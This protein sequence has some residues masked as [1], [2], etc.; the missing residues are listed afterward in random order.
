MR[1]LVKGKER[2][3]SREP[4]LHRYGG[5]SLNWARS[6][7][8][9]LGGE[10]SLTRASLLPLLAL[11]TLASCEEGSVIETRRAQDGVPRP[12]LT[13][14]APVRPGFAEMADALGWDGGVP[15][16]EVRLHR[17][18]TPLDQW[19][20]DTTDVGGLVRFPDLLPG[21]YRVAAFRG[22]E[23]GEAT[24]AVARALADGLLHV[25]SPGDSIELDL[26]LDRAGLMI[27]EIYTPSHDGSDTYDL[28]H[29]HRIRNA[30]DQTI[31]LDGMLYGTGFA[32]IRDFDTYF[33][34]ENTAR[35]R[36]DPEGLWAN[37]IHRFPGSGFEYPIRPG[38]SKVIA[39][40][41][42]DHRPHSDYGIDLRGA[43]F[44][45]LGPA[46]VDN[47]AVPNMLD[48]GLEADQTSVGHGV[49]GPPPEPW[50]LSEPVDLMTAPRDEMCGVTCASYLRIPAEAVIDV[51][52]LWDDAYFDA[53][54]APCAH[55][56][57]RRF[58]RL[59]GG[60]FADALDPDWEWSALRRVLRKEDGRPIP[61][62]TDVTLVDFEKVRRTIDG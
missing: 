62:D 23:A 54:A 53:Q 52:V 11:A 29:Y 35:F 14:V 50:F 40:D 38:E 46:D 47:P 43:D 26:R 28:F 8:H 45:L 1:G 10:R 55:S 12:G 16:V 59:H 48:V 58:D 41:A 13:L 42:I 37:K 56:V 15:G 5:F 49:A 22:I 31:H 2:Q 21:T 19:L 20:V 7:F 17:I 24:G 6:L 60:F 39:L 44:E 51:V 34:C 61:L 33:T 36:T 18:G 32:L 27:E 9:G 25:V 4:C 3:E 30:S 57:P